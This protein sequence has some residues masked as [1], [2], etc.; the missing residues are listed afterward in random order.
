MMSFK[1]H[2]TEAMPIGFRFLCSV[3]EISVSELHARCPTVGIDLVRSVLR[4][5]RE[6][7]RVA[8]PR[9]GRVRP[10]AEKWVTSPTYG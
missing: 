9:R 1:P 2:D 3:G 7:E 4:Q 10:L 6:A 8:C 5:R